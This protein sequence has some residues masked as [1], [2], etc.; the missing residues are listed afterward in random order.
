MSN[1]NEMTASYP[2]GQ[3]P[4]LPLFKMLK[5][6]QHYSLCGLPVWYESHLIWKNHLKYEFSKQSS[7][8]FQK[9]VIR[10]NT[11][12]LLAKH[13]KAPVVLVSGNSLCGWRTYLAECNM[14]SWTYVKHVLQKYGRNCFDEYTDLSMS[15]KVAEQNHRSVK[16]TS[17][18]IVFDPNTPV[19]NNQH[20]VLANR[21]N[22][23]RLI[24][25]SL[26]ML[27]AAKVRLMLT[28]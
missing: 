8:L 14:A 20:S 21:T 17:A 13:L 27:L 11:K 3:P 24:D 6:I 22:K 19:T 7:A 26:R 4:L 12:R 25:L 16:N 28:T 9:G 1:S 15:T 10:N 2:L 5:S 18:D 23:S